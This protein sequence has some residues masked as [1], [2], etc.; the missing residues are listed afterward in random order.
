MSLPRNLAIE[1][2]ELETALL[3]HLQEFIL[4]LGNGFCFESRQKRI[5]IGEKYY[6]IDLVF[7]HRIL[8]YH[9]IIDL[10]VE[11]FEHANAGQLNTYINYYKKNMMKDFDNPPVGILMVTDKDSALVEYA[12]AGMDE[13][14]FVSQYLLQF[15]DKETLVGFVTNELKE[16]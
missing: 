7:Y 12:T 16:L 6:F 4:E 5:L 9:V 1:E 15:P 3:D 8:R 13:N 11:D 10:K 14:L 2:T